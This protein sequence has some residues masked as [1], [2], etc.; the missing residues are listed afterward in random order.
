MESESYERQAPPPVVK[1][2]RDRII[3]FHDRHLKVAPITEEAAAAFEDVAK[4]ITS[5]KGQAA[6]ERIRPHVPNWSKNAEMWAGVG[7]MT[8]TVAGSALA[9]EGLI[10]G[11]MEKHRME[12]AVG[13]L[14]AANQVTATSELKIDMRPRIKRGFAGVLA[15]GIFGGLR[16]VT[17]LTHRVGIPIARRI[18]L[19]VDGIMLKKEQKMEVKQ[20]FVGRGKA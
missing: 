15:G 6:V 9:A 7:D 5:K 20:V 17:H 13:V 12:K 18:A 4:H 3:A 10:G 14:D 2:V 1:T 16:P 8:L 11:L 19:A